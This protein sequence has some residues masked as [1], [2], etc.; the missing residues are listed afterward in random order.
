MKTPLMTCT[1]S[2]LTF[3]LLA[4]LTAL[5]A[6]PQIPPPALWADY[7]PDKG[8]FK[9]E[10]VSQETKGGIYYI[11]SY[12][13]AYVLGEE[14][15]VYCRYGVRVCAMGTWTERSRARSARKRSMANPSPIRSKPP[16]TF[17]MRSS[18]EC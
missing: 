7:D 10:I 16:T 18:A 2:L 6:A 8:D 9:E 17:G 13:S 14:I 5:H 11:D 12:I 15:R 3:L 1:R 4:P